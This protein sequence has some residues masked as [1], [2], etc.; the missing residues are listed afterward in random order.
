LTDGSAHGWTDARV[1][2]AGAVGLVSLA[3]LLPVERRLAAPMVRLSLF[4][5]RQF[6]AINVTT[7]LFY[8][9]FSAVSYLLVLQFQLQLG[10]SAAQA[11]AAL[12]PWAAV[13][14]AI[15][16]LSGTLVSRVG[17]RWL[18]VSGML[19]VGAAFAWLG[20]AAHHGASY[21]GAILPPV[22]LWGFGLGLTVTPLTAA[23][24]AA[25]R[26][27]DLGEASAINDAAA[28]LGGV[29]AI[30]AV[31]ALIGATGGNS[32]GHALA[33]G[34]QPAMT[35]AAGLTTGAA[36]IAA[37]FVSNDRTVASRVAP[38]APYHACPLPNSAPSS[39][40]QQQPPEES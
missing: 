6:D 2:V 13:F 33:G 26:D 15:S 3:A 38:P 10:Y 12:V 18:M 25:V 9:G 40:H 39:H 27:P 22:A 36:V 14:V 34:Y 32:L 1:L 35:A 16:P 30:A 7:V 4:A 11:G 5:S 21:A 19:T 28:R 8:G 23:V 24:L 17:P 29:I 37:L 20:A 31:P